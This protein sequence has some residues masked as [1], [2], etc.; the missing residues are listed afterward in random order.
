MKFLPKSDRKYIILCIT[1]MVLAACTV[2]KR[3][4]IQAVNPAEA[5]IS[6]DAITSLGQHF[7]AIPDSVQTS[8]YWYWMSDNL[9]VDG[10]TKDLE[11][12]KKVGINRVFI[13]N[14]WQ[15]DIKPGKV[16]IFTDEWWAV[17]HA[18]LK[19][20]TELNIEV[21]IFNSPGWSQSGGP[22]VKPDQA[23]RYL[24]SSE[25]RVKGPAK[26]VKVLPKPQPS[27]QDVKV[28]AYPVVADYSNDIQSLNP[29]ISTKPVISNIK[30]ALDNNNLT[31]I[32]LTKGNTFSLSIKSKSTY[33][34]R[35][36][37]IVPKSN[38]LVVSG[39]L[40]A[41][42]NGAFKTIKH[43]TVNR[44]NEALNVGFSPKAAGVISIPATKAN[45]FRIVF[46]EVSDGEIAEIRLS[47]TPYVE[48][49]AEKS[50][51]KMW[52]D[53]FPEW[54][55]YLWDSQPAVTDKSYL[56]DP[57]KVI[58]ISSYMQPD[59][60]LQWD[61]PAGNWIVERS[62]MT[63]TQVKNGPASPEGTGL[64]VDKMSKEHV[65][66]HFNAYL[67]EILKRI[68][69]ADRKTWKVAVQD[70]YETGGENWT[71]GFIEQFKES[72]GYAPTA[73]IPVLQ[74]KVVGSQEMSDRF[75]WDLRRLIADNIAYKYVGGL[76]DI[77]HQHGLHTWLENYGHWGFPGEF[78]QYGGQSD[79][80]AGEF[81]TEGNLGNIENKAASSA[82][83]IYGKTRVSAES[84]TAGG[85]SYVRYPAMFKK[86]GD[87]FFTEGINNTLLHVYIQQP[88]EDKNPG[89]NTN[90]ST[91]FN[92][93]NTWFYD[94]DIFL[95]YIKRTN[96]LLQQG[97]YVADAAY[98][99]GEDAPKMTGVQDPK[100]P[101][102]H[103]FDYINGEV[104]RTRLSVKDGKLVL[105]DGM[106]YS[107]LVLPKL[108]T[109]RP[110]LLE[111]IKTLVNDGAVVWGP[112]PEN[113]P[114]LQDYP[115]A[116]QKVKQLADE[117]W[118]N[119][120]GK[121]VFV[122]HLGKGMVINGMDIKE[123]LNLIKVSPDCQ[124]S[125]ATGS[126]IL[127]IHRKL[128]EA[129]V[130]FLSNQEDNQVKFSAAFRSSGY[131]PQLW[132]PVDGIIRD[133]PEFSQTGQTTTIPLSLAP[134]ESA[135]IVFR[136]KGN[137][138]N[139]NEKSNYPAVVASIP[140]NSPWSVSFE[141]KLHGPA[142]PVVF[143]ELT[144]WAVSENDSIRYYSGPATYRN[145][146]KLTKVK[147][148]QKVYLNLGKLKA[149]AKVHVNGI[150]VGGA[151]TAPYQVEITEA[152]KDG[153]NLI[154]VKVV[155]TWVNRLIGDSRLP[156]E[157]RS[158]WLNYNPYTPTSKLEKS[159]LFGPVTVDIIP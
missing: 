155:N 46:T 18:A 54:G 154:E 66:A 108:K 24:S 31:G 84:F 97:T 11:A 139:S 103:S 53:P 44:S 141:S 7:S 36:L 118:G 32:T 29:V 63:P 130:Y 51:A 113:S 78:L 91:E 127:F 65:T 134:A 126:N 114:S 106:S 105:P 115:Q 23:M 96:M 92:R 112:K 142:K 93:K 144:D 95:K 38:S 135:F 25:I 124:I 61:V 47:S 136:K 49:F 4:S 5:T 15:D 152:L 149:I 140:L 28:I 77:S 109:T 151:W 68:P 2:K 70:S 21:G 122:N 132:N 59:G 48:Q 120:D 158:T 3:N 89:I 58:D 94:M 52:Q 10:V 62:G 12:M 50:L 82:A 6:S 147:A 37:T 148:G 81:W 121:K 35:S 14:I 119:T 40:Q 156:V 34:V 143:K 22:W 99:I 116:D 9:S 117:L 145:H 73:Y 157:K 83:H 80:I 69:A 111:K 110:E 57:A 56:I 76:T 26:L 104:I 30:Y 138:N 102:G 100:L 146:I 67:G 75:L 86:R 153:D 128:A 131:I 33:T 101:Q 19:K 27:F 8:I 98:F 64:E 16:K 85:Q 13:G 125:S 17:L 39:D 20:A 123:A 42:T 74:G 45:N 150:D 129:E 107:L 137:S 60:T 90:F 1:A 43:F 159:G 133:L 79:E 71:D 72:Y 87:R 88:Y 55:S 41:E